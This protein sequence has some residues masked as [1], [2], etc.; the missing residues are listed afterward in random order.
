MVV[1]VTEMPA[2]NMGAVVGRGDGDDGGD[3]ELFAVVVVVVI[4]V[5][6]VVVVV[7]L[8]LKWQLHYCWL[9]RML[10]SSL[11]T[12]FFLLFI[13]LIPSCACIIV[14]ASASTCICS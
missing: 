14:A 10:S 9:A 3:D 8:F 11:W 12:S 5:V 13:S 6:V 2:V 1:A 4:V 7:V